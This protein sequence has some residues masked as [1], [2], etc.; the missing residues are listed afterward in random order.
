MKKVPCVFMRDFTE[1]SPNQ[2]K[3]YDE[4]NPG[5]EWVLNGFGIATKKFDGTSVFINESGKPFKRC[6]AKNGKTPPADWVA[7]QPEADPVTGHWPG[8]VPVDA[9]SNED[10]RHREAFTNLQNSV[11]HLSHLQTGTYELVGPNVN[12][13]PENFPQH[14]LVF[15]GEV[16][17]PN[18]PRTFDGIRDMLV[19]LN[20]EGV[21]F[22]KFPEMPS[23]DNT[24][25]KIRLTDFGLTRVKAA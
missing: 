3:V 19:A 5:C 21:V 24:M 1:G 22:W 20:I 23:T 4:V 15:H 18:F 11:G 7:A 16:I 9:D 2:G 6:D 8:W 10:A 14:S 25:A 12:G 17:Y 13:N